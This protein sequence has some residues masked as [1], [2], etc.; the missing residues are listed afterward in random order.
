MKC[1]KGYSIKNG[2][3]SPSRANNYSNKKILGLKKPWFFSILIV[4]IILIAIMHMTVFN[5]EAPAIHSI[6]YDEVTEFSY[7]TYADT[8]SLSGMDIRQ[9]CYNTDTLRNQ[10]DRLCFVNGINNADDGG[11]EI[12]CL[13]ENIDL[14]IAN[15]AQG[16]RGIGT[17]R[18]N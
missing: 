18:T 2:K 12:L 9:G 7:I 13:C 14:T 1:K 16:E 15:P 10:Q 17:V 6:S 4:S 5:E 8:F 3:C 11:L